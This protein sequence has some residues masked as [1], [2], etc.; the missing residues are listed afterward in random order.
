M[1]CVDLLGVLCENFDVKV[2]DMMLMIEVMMYIDIL[3]DLCVWYVEVCV[4]CYVWFFVLSVDFD[5]LWIDVNLCDGVLMLM[6]LCC[7]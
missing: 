2:Y 6:I 3:V 1:L 5:M 7:E 4:M